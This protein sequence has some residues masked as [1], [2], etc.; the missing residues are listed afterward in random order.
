MQEAGRFEIEPE[1]NAI[2]GEVVE[3]VGGILAGAGVHADAAVFL[4]DA[5]IEVRD[6]VGIGLIDGGLELLFESLEL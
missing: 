4:D 3:V 1:L 5:R 6:D 2:G